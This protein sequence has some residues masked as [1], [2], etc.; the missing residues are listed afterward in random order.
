M[1]VCRPCESTDIPVICTL[2]RTAEELFYMFPTARFP[3]SEEQLTANLRSRWHPTVIATGDDGVVGFG[4]LYGLSG[5][6]CSVGNFIV[7]T[8]QRVSC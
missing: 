2:P 4:N 1:Y 3:L 5:D 7:A 6:E 8:A